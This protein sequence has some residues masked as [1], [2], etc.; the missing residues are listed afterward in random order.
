MIFCPPTAICSPQL[1]EKIRLEEVKIKD[2]TRMH[3]ATAEDLK[4]VEQD[5]LDVQEKCR[6]IHLVAQAEVDRTEEKRGDLED[7]LEAAK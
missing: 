7:I 5:L 2:I 6:Q 1:E 4:V 3:E